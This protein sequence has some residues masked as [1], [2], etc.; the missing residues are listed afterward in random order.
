M[1]IAGTSAQHSTGNLSSADIHAG[2]STSY[3]PPP[4][5]S[6]SLPQKPCPILAHLP[7]FSPIPLHVMRSSRDHADVPRAP[8]SPMSLNP[9]HPSVLC[10]LIHGTLQSHATSSLQCHPVS[11]RRTTC[12]PEASCRSAALQTQEKAPVEEAPWWAAYTEPITN[13]LENASFQELLPF[14]VPHGHSNCRAHW[15]SR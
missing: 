8:F 14:Y 13:Q 1:A 15:D 12:S 6:L 5:P 4:S 7:C 2:R 10:H 3:D 11:C 9:W